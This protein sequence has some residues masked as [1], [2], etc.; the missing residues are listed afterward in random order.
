MRAAELQAAAQAA[1]SHATDLHASLQAAQG[2]ATELHATVEK[3]RR[4]RIEAR[5]ADEQRWDAERA[6]L[7]TNAQTAE[8]RAADLYSTLE[9]ERQE[10]IE[11]RESDRRQWNSEHAGLQAELRAIESRAAESQATLERERQDRAD[12]AREE[13]TRF[14]TVIAE[15][16][17]TTNAQQGEYDSLLAR[18]AAV[19]ADA[20]RLKDQY[21]AERLA[22]ED[23]WE[24][25]RSDWSVVRT[26]LQAH[27]E[28]ADA[29]CTAQRDAA[30]ALRAQGDILSSLFAI[31]APRL[32]PS[33]AQSAA[34]AN[35]HRNE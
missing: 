9:R 13:R 6:A 19:E 10:R 26:A 22:R 20:Q 17:E 30:H 1:E 27:L 11:A 33:G 18:M 8:A 35:P 15:L 2:H 12:T 14:E 21:D 25:A 4:E 28:T 34:G 32:L 24:Q 5:E 31:D 16:V 29:L 23:A 7:S 3:E